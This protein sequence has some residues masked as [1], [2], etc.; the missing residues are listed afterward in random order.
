M[1]TSAENEQ[2]DEDGSDDVGRML[3]VSGG[4]GLCVCYLLR[5]MSGNEWNS[6]FLL[7]GVPVEMMPRSKGAVTPQ[8]CPFATSP[9][10]GT[11]Q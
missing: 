4:G 5:V 11:N 9:A 8:S 3:C 10:G 7:R 6:I 2:S 1:H